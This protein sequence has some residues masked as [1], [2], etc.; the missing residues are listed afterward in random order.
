MRQDPS[1]AFR[2]EQPKVTL[3]SALNDLAGQWRLVVTDLSTG[4]TAEHAFKLE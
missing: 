1:S 3:P 2:K 4:A